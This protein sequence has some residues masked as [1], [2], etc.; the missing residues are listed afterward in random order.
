MKKVLLV[1]GI[2]VLVLISLRIVAPPRPDGRT[3]HTVP[4]STLKRSPTPRAT[5]RRVQ[6][7][8]AALRERQLQD[9]L[10]MNQRLDS[11]V[12][13][14]VALFSTNSVTNLQA[15]H[16]AHCTLYSVHVLEE[17]IE[18]YRTRIEADLESYKTNGLREAL[19]KNALVSFEGVQKSFLSRIEEEH[20]QGRERLQRETGI[21][22]DVFYKELFSITVNNYAPPNF[23]SLLNY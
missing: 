20:A 9:Y 2:A 13:K 16:L 22:N 11:Q 19:T 4:D 5:I 1:S 8:E 15:I 12:G 14:I 21:S 3:T 17:N 10:E 23:F 6:E 18:E 7:H